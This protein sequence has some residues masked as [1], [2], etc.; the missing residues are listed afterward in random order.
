MNNYELVKQYAGGIG[1][2]KKDS[3]EITYLVNGVKYKFE[4]L[5]GLII[6]ANLDDKLLEILNNNNYP[7]RDEENKNIPGSFYFFRFDTSDDIFSIF[8]KYFE[9]K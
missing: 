1:G 6:V 8:D 5:Y 9:A 3:F 7:I 4:V 2:P